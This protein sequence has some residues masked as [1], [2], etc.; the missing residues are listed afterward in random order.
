[1]L[2]RSFSIVLVG[3]KLSVRNGEGGQINKS[4]Y[5]RGEVCIHTFCLYISMFRESHLEVI[6]LPCPA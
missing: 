5:A 6:W 3:W 1:M 2:R 4:T